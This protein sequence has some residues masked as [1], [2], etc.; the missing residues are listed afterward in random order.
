MSKAKTVICPACGE[1]ALFSPENRFRP[2]CSA[3]CRTADL[4]AWASEKYVIGGEHD[5][6]AE[7]SAELPQDGVANS[8]P[9]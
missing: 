7:S 4:G 1:A 9:H 2:F 3:R 5:P 8:R 6:L